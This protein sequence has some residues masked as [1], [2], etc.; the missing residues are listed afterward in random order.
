[1]FG[2]GSVGT[3]KRSGERLLA[4]NEVDEMTP[5]TKK[6][7][8]CPMSKVFEHLPSSL[9]ECLF[10]H[11]NRLHVSPTTLAFDILWSWV[12]EADL[13]EFIIGREVQILQTPTWRN[14]RRM[15]G[16]EPGV[17]GK[18][19]S[20][21]WL[22]FDAEFPGRRRTLWKEHRGTVWCMADEVGE[23]AFAR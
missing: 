16:L 1:M 20:V 21:D 9:T 18:I 3:D 14:G 15:R 12:R 17:I 6:E 10:H 19:V 11:A 13:E 4:L 7:R 8:S 23:Q 22:L 2:V 5:G